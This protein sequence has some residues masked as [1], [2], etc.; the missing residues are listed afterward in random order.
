MQLLV[1]P[2]T[3]WTPKSMVVQVCLPILQLPISF[4]IIAGACSRV[5][6]IRCL[7]EQ[8]ACASL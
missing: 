5:A 6:A 2:K 4:A 1:M 8:G 7:N 3:G